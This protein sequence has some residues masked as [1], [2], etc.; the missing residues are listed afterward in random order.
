MVSAP[1]YE[2]TF[3]TIKAES[4]GLPET[5]PCGMFLVKYK[6]SGPCDLRPLYLAIPCIL[7]PDISDTT[8]TFSV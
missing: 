6:Y 7:R 8:C 2:N 5:R 1:P 3:T 4:E